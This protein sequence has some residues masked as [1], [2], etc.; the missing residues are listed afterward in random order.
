MRYYI[1]AI[2]VLLVDQATKWLIVQRLAI[3]DEVPVIGEFFQITS[4]RNKGAAFGILQNQRWFFILITLMVVVGVIWYLEKMRRAG[5]KLMPFALSLLLGGA[6]GNFIDRLLFGQVV[7]F[8]KFRF[9]FNWFGTPVD[10]TYPIFNVADSA[11]CVGVALIFVDA[12]INWRK[13]RRG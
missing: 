6:V 4:H 5:H 12:L 13:E 8:L 11:I 3:G 2:I 9:Q 10:Y 1:Y 7:D